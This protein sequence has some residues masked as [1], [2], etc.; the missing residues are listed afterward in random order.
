MKGKRTIVLY[1]CVFVSLF[2]GNNVF[3]A[4]VDSD[5]SATTASNASSNAT[6]TS[7]DQYVANARQKVTE[8]DY[9]AAA[10]LYQQALKLDQQHSIARRELKEVLL[11]A[12]R[13]DPES[14]FSDVEWRL[15]EEA[16]MDRKNEK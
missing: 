14:E 13:R 10:I 16:A 15:L 11:E 8:Q 12:R 1:L 5:H 4:S 9:A 6:S 3:A 2:M 7:A